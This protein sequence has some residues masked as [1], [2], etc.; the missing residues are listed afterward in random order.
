MTDDS[1]HA[2]PSPVLDPAQV[3][4]LIN[5]DQGSGALFGQ[6]VDLFVGSAPDRMERLGRH[7][8]SAEGAPLAEAA[9]ALRGAAGNVGAT[10]LA[11]LCERIESAAKAGDLAAAQEALAALPAV[12]EETRRALLHAAGRAA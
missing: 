11:S 1:H 3:A 10:R 9:H 8:A 5:L 12:Y 4:D 6:F 7:A 2:D